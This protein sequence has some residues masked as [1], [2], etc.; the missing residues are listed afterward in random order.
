MIARIGFWL[1][2][3]ASCMLSSSVRADSKAKPPKK[4]ATKPEARAIWNHSGTGAYP[5]DWDRTA[6]E[7]G[8]AGFNMILPNMLWGGAAHFDSD[9]LPPSAVYRRYGDQLDQCVKAAHK[10]GLE[11]HVWKVCWNLGHL[12]PIDFV[13]KLRKADRLQVSAQG[14]KKDWL[15]PSHP[16]NQKLELAALLEVARKYP[17]NGLHLDYIRYPGRDFCYCEGCRRRFEKASRRRVADWPKVCRSGDRRDEYDAWRCKQIT[18]L[19]ENVSRRA[20]RLRPKIKISAAVWGGYP[21][22]YT[23]I[24]QDC[25][26][27][28]K[29]GHV[30]FLCPM[31]YTDSD[32][33]FRSL[34]G[35]QLKL[36]PNGIPIYPGIGATSSKTPLS[37]RRVFDQIQIARRL[38][39]GGFTVFNLNRK[40]AKELVPALAKLLK[41][42][43]TVPPHRSA[44]R[45]K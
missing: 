22:G 15:C 31:N 11:V 41:P 36:L 12:A 44:K 10:H 4:P 1:A 35:K 32:K 14:E 38:G 20:K 6:K 18:R 23:S 5:G 34:T 13:A 24:A 9:V 45:G 30:D 39:A 8:E 43:E 17:V 21:R 2:V 33:A 7:L 26:S 42:T 19:V 40:T 3:L 27:W 16:A 25:V 29:A 28:A 37:A